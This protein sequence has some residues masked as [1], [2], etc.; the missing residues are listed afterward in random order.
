LIRGRRHVAGPL[1]VLILS[2]IG[3]AALV[4][5][6]T[7]DLWLV[8]HLTPGQPLPLTVR[9]PMVGVYRDSVAGASYRQMR[10]T[11]P[12]GTVLAAHRARFINA[13]DE[14]RRPP[15]RALMIGISLASLLLFSLFTTY[16]SVLGGSARFLRTHIVLVA[17]VIVLLLIN[18]LLLVFTSWS[19][20]WVPLLAVVIPVALHLG[21]RVAAATSVACATALGLL[22]PIDLP[23]LI[24]LICQGLAVSATV[25][26][27]AK[28]QMTMGGTFAA[29]AA[30]LFAY[31]AMSLLL[32]QYVRI[33]GLASGQPTISAVLRSDLAAS[34][35][36]PA[37]GG[38]IA[39]A[40]APVVQRMLRQVSRSRLAALADFEHPLLRRLSA[41]CPGTWAHSLSMANMAEMAANAIHANGL[42]VRVGAYYHDVGKSVQPEYFIENQ[43]GKNPHDKLSPEVSADAIVSHVTEG[44]KLSRKH[45][46]PEAIIEFIYT[47]HGTDRLEYFWHKQLKSSKGESGNEGRSPD[48]RDF[49]YQGM[50]PPTKETA[51]LALCDSVEAAARSIDSSDPKAIAQLVRQIVFGKLVNGVLDTSGLTISDLRTIT[52]SMIETLRSSMHTRVK[53][54]WQEEQEKRAESRQR[55]AESD[56]TREAKQAPMSSEKTKADASGDMQAGPATT[57]KTSDTASSAQRAGHIH[58]RATPGHLHRRATPGHLHWRAAPGHLHWRAAPGHLHLPVRAAVE[59]EEGGLHAGADEWCG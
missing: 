42:L 16:L 44:V 49:R 46:L 11:L 37:A 54:P 25:R 31:T 18:K 15:G 9:V 24:V 40:M 57:P 21:R 22:T 14:T 17:L 53:Y 38:L 50:R 2:L 30:G 6:A 7:V 47:H 39:L 41:Q 26:P 20:L 10:L 55:G 8:P 51:I 27:Y 36:A 45:K 13:Y 58:P 5:T 12:R 4:A 43:S 59:R 28:I 1:S 52:E 3:A 29:A 32:L 35:G 19:S 56:A 33:D 48:D 23:V 34:F